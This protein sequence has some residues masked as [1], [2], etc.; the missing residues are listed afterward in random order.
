[1][2]ERWVAKP[3]L[4]IGID[5]VGKRMVFTPN[6]WEG[7]LLRSV[8]TGCKP[9]STII[10]VPVVN[11]GR[12]MAVNCRAKMRFRLAT[13]KK[14]EHMLL[15]N[16]SDYRELHWT[17]NPEDTV[18]NAYRPISIG[19]GDTEYVDLIVY[20]T[21]LRHHSGRVK[22]IVVGGAEDDTEHMLTFYAKPLLL[23]GFMK[24]P[25]TWEIPGAEYYRLDPQTPNVVRPDYAML[26]EVEV[27]VTC[28]NAQAQAV[29]Y[30][31][32]LCDGERLG[33]YVWPTLQQV[34]EDLQGE[35]RKA[36]HIYM[37]T[38]PDKG[39]PRPC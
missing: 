1:V 3:K 2:Y 39:S 20:L 16:W 27:K 26:Y 10:R 23:S 19:A 34:K 18:D 29:L 6:S 14:D 4:E 17:G 31:I 24:G 32:V 15:G 8:D 22:P 30:K 36:K 12:R 7:V 37:Y 38:K 28:E 11:R 35:L 33:I 21:R 9:Y 5:D 13:L 25:C